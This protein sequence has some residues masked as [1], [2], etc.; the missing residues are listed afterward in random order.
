MT[1]KNG[2]VA[3]F[4]GSAVLAVVF[5][6]KSAMGIMPQMDIIMMLSAMMGMGAVMGWIAH[7]AIGTLAWGGLFALAN[8]QIPGGSQIGKG[9]VLGLAA[10]GVMMVMVMPMAG[11]G[12][13]GLRFGMMGAAMPLILHI[14]FGAVLGYVYSVLGQRVAHPA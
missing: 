3:G 5:V 7:F 6:M 2:F 4:A 1:L 14:I 10:W 11:G 9:I 12:M 13:F 8:A